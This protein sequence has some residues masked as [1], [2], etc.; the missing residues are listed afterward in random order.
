M[1]LADKQPYVDE[2]ILV[3][4]VPPSFW[5]GFLNGLWISAILWAVIIQAIRSWIR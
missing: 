2:R 5:I 3:P 4:V 1:K